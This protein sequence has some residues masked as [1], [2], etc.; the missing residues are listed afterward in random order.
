MPDRGKS[1]QTET[2]KHGFTTRLKHR[3]LGKGKEA[4]LVDTKFLT[5]LSDIKTVGRY[6][7]I[8]KLGQGSMG[9]VYLGRD[10]YIKRNV[11]IKVSRHA[12]DVVGQ[13]IDRYREKFFVEAQSAGRLVHPNIV[14]IYDAGMYKD[15]C[16]VTME[17]INGYTLKKFCRKDYFLPVSK[18]VEIMFAACN[19][20]D[21]AHKKGVVHRDIK[22]SNIMLDKTGHLKITD[23]GIAQIKSEQTAS[24]GIIGSLNYMSPEHVREKRIED[25][26]DIFSLGSVL[27]ELLTGEK[28]F[29]GENDFSIMYKIVREDPVPMRKIRPELPEILVKITKKALAKDPNMRYQ[30]CGDFAYDLR[31]ALR[32]LKGTIKKG[33][34]RDVI[35]YVHNVPFFENFSKE[36]VKEILNAS[37]LIRVRKGRIVVAE[38]D[39]DDSFYIILSGKAAVNK[40]K[41][42]IALIERGECFGEMA[43]VSGQARAATV[44]AYT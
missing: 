18:V 1:K 42:N 23:F 35:D 26:S 39:I 3:F 17:Y 6:E 38:G 32:G 44:L 29:F 15:F 21:Y 20:L 43:Y 25:R 33:K 9:M 12:T 28:A 16:Y 14:A 24:K 2:K 11:G 27:Y 8:A 31:V 4:S 22:P 41:K 7:I 40:N 19:A 36:Q 30:T 10:P 34:V 13:D 37:N 5:E